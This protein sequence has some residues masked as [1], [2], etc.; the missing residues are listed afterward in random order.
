MI[1]YSIDINIGN[2]SVS[3]SKEDEPNLAAPGTTSL[4]KIFCNLLETI[5]YSKEA[6]IEGVNKYLE[7]K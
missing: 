5:G 1:D 6:V 3:Y 4:V 7:G 2:E